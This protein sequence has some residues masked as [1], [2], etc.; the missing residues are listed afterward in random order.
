MRFILTLSACLIYCSLWS[1]KGKPFP[2]LEGENLM[3]EVINIPTDV[4]DKHTLIGLAFTKDS[5]KFLKTWF[6]P[7]YTQLISKPKEGDLFAISYDVNVYFI[8]MLTGAKRPAYEKV[9]NKVEEDTDP[10]LHPHIL[11]YKG[12]MKKYR[13][14]LNITDK[15]L[16]YFYLLDKSGNVIYATSGIYTEAKMQRIIDALPF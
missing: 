1:Q 15:D 4:Q 3:N 10:K 16:P 13:D 8:P 11:F 9:M 2:A 7:I 12:T 6:D 14:A 5:E